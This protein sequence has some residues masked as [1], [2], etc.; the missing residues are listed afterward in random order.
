MTSTLIHFLVATWL[1]TATTATVYVCKGPSSKKYHI[2][3]DCS[4]LRNCST[5]IYKVSLKEATEDL[6]R[7]RC[8]IASCR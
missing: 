7:T 3:R 5:N 1:L 8:A 6:N 2:T 4:G